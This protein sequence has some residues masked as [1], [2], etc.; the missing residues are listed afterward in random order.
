MANERPPDRPDHSDPSPVGQ[1]LIYR[2]GAL[3]LQVRLEGQTAWLPQRLIAELYQVA[4][5]TVNEHLSNIYAE[6]ELDPAATIR[7]F[8]IVQP[9]GTRQVARMVDHYNLDAIL[10][11]GYRTRSHRGWKELRYGE[12]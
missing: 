9:E 7:K 6:G 10:A 12:N 4:V 1:M 2:D 5:P 3:N 11:V 8:R